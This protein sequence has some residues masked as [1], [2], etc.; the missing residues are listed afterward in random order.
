MDGTRIV[1]S[2]YKAEFEIHNIEPCNK[3]GAKFGTI[4]VLRNTMWVVSNFQK[5]RYEGVLFNIIRVTRGG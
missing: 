2:R 3:T 5:K 1:C 4:Q